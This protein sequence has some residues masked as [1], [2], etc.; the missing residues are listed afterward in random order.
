M[1]DKVRLAESRTHKIKFEGIAKAVAIEQRKGKK[2]PV[3]I[4]HKVTSPKIGIEPNY[5]FQ[6]AEAGKWYKD[7]KDSS[8]SQVS[9]EKDLNKDSCRWVVFAGIVLY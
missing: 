7:S 8:L 5:Q 4:N 6:T 1:L 3:S 2:T 9:E